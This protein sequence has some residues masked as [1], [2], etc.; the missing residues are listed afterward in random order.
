[1]SSHLMGQEL[2][3]RS[4]RYHTDPTLLPPEDVRAL[5]DGVHSHV[6]EPCQ[7][8]VRLAHWQGN[9]LERCT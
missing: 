9:L 6:T 3:H 8:T 2:R 5:M 1:M 4:V 7:K